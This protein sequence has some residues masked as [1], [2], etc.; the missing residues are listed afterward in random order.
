[1]ADAVAASV[2]QAPGLTL[3]ALLLA[4][5]AGWAGP[6]VPA[7]SADPGVF[8]WSNARGEFV[9][10]LAAGQV[11]GGATAGS[12]TTTYSTASSLYSSG[13]SGGV[14]RA[15]EPSGITDFHGDMQLDALVQGNG[16]ATGNLLAGILTIRSGSGDAALGIGAG[17]TLAVGYAVDS[18]AFEGFND[19]TF[20]FA[21]TYTHPLLSYL[22]PY[23][24]FFNPRL[25]SWGCEPRPG[26]FC[27]GTNP[28]FMPWGRDVDNS[29]AVTGWSLVST[30]MVPEPGSVALFAIGLAALVVPR[31]AWRRAG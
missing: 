21:L 8:G 9:V 16:T 28:P 22:G 5:L 31:R 13:T 7:T 26:V 14:L 18:A 1:V 11:Y 10:D 20:L 12:L 3:S 2:R 25:G 27:A 30:T 29:L 19:T 15:I 24:T 23:A 6:T 4:P 17:Q